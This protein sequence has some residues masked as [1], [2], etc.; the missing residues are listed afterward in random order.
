MPNDAPFK[1]ALRQEGYW[2]VAYFDQ[3]KSGEDRVEI[4][5]ILMGVAQ[6][7]PAIKAKFIELNQMILEGVLKRIGI[8]APFWNDPEPA[9]ENERSGNAD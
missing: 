6:Q 2:W 8:A 5:R 4:G 3:L 7:E 9:P 1:L